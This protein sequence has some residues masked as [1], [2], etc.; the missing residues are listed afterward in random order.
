VRY[1]SDG[2]AIGSRAFVESVFTAYRPCFGPKRRTGARPMRGGAWEGLCAL[3]DLR[4]DV[5][6]GPGSGPENS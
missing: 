6:R 4:K 3:R 5:I 2:V 1:F